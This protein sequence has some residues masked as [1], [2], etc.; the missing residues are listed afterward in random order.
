MFLLFWL[1]ALFGA[2]GSGIYIVVSL[3]IYIKERIIAKRESRE[4]GPQYADTLRNI[5]VLLLV[6]LILLGLFFGLAYLGM[7]GM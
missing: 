5:G 2:I 7:R 6:G 4:I 3:I 1:G